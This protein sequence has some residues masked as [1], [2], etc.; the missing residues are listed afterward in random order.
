MFYLILINDFSLF[1][2]YSLN[3]ANSPLSAENYDTIV[4]RFLSNIMARA[5]DSRPTYI[6]L[7]SDHGLQ[8]EL[9]AI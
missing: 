2:S 3:A 4:H 9:N 7:R 5:H 1:L 6:I 8:G